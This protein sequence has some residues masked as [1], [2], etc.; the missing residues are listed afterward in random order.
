MFFV[1]LIVT[2]V[3]IVHCI[4]EEFTIAL[5]IGLVLLL[6]SAAVV[7]LN[8]INNEKKFVKRVNAAIYYLE[9][10]IAQIV[11]FQRYF[12]LNIRKKDEILE[13]LMYL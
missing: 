12:T 4:R 1:A 8:S 7:V 5:V 3:S 6:G 2:T 11:D 13:K 9:N 10:T